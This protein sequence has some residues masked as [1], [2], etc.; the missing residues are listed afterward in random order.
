MVASNPSLLLLLPIPSLTA[1]RRR[2]RTAVP[3]RAKRQGRALD[4]SA[5]R[6]SPQSGHATRSESVA[7]TKPFWMCVADVASRFLLS[8]LACNMV[9]RRLRALCGTSL[10]FTIPASHTF[11]CPTEACRRGPTRQASFEVHCCECAA[12]ICVPPRLVG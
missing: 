12:A 1:A 3:S 11:E 4:R 9:A 2:L 7:C 10:H 8:Y 6:S 5:R